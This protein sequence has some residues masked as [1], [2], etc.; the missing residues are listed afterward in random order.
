M[1]LRLVLL[2]FFWDLSGVVRGFPGISVWSSDTW[3][4]IGRNVM[5]QDQSRGWTRRVLDWFRSS[6]R[7]IVIHPVLL[8]YVVEKLWVT[9]PRCIVGCYFYSQENRLIDMTS[10]WL[11]Y[12]LNKHTSDWNSILRLHPASWAVT[13]IVPLIRMNIYGIV[14]MLF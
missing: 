6:R 10:F 9:Y 13:V 1:L 12:N 11:C 3:S 8:Y 2:S 5:M 7:V 14:K 4:R